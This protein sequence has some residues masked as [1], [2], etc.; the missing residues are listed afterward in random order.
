MIPTETSIAPRR[1]RN[2]VARKSCTCKGNL[3][4]RRHGVDLIR[5]YHSFLVTIHEFP[6]DPVAMKR[7][8]EMSDSYTLKITNESSQPA[9]RFAVFTKL[10]SDAAQGS[11]LAGGQFNMA[12]I[13]QP[14]NEH[15][16]YTF[17]WD[18]EFQIMWAAT[19]YQAGVI[20][21]AGGS[22]DAD[23]N[24]SE[25]CT[26]KFDYV[27]GDWDLSYEEVGSPTPGQL[28]VNDTTT[29][30]PYDKQPSTIALAIAGGGTT[31][32]LQPLPAI[33]DFAGPNMHQ[34]FTLH[35]AY[36]VA[37]GSFKQGQMVDLD[38]VTNL[39][40]VRYEHGAMNAAVTLDDN[41]IWHIDK[42]L[43]RI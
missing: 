27:N 43:T 38:N 21:N 37:A 28:T 17:S 16:H 20:W 19:G 12:W 35:P 2:T 1:R 6:D 14:I 4:H 15:N 33:G 22:I 23:P 18:L 34:I 42:E 9:L 41:N 13:V 29:I 32:G 36:F 25:R 39:Y 10:P 24:D 3:L 8:Y 31:T 26:M 11:R 40:E 7:G 5:R 30:P